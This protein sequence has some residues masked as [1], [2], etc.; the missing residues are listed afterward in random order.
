MPARRQAIRESYKEM[1]A[2]LVAGRA[3]GCPPR[4]GR[5][6]INYDDENQDNHKVVLI[7]GIYEYTIL[8][9]YTTHNRQTIFQ[10]PVAEAQPLD[11]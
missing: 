4:G 6:L 5:E 10:G 1:S 9:T 3:G 7:P 2:R 11:I 8:C